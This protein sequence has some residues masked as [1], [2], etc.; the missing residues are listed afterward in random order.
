V[1]DFDQRL[2]EEWQAL[3][4]ELTSLLE[5]HG[6]QDPFGDGDFWIVDD[7]WGSPQHKVCIFRL[8][9]LTRPLALEIQRLIRQYSLPW[10]VLLSLDN[11]EHRPTPDDLGVTVRKADIEEAWSQDRMQRAFGSEFRWRLTLAAN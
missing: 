4:A 10:E 9:F 1:N 8:P 2:D 11:P 3:Y 6:K 5:R 7:S